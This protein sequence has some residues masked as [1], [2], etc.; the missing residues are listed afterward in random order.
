MQPWHACW[1]PAYTGQVGPYEGD[2]QGS[3]AGRGAMQGRQGYI[4]HLLCLQLR[5]LRMLRV[6]PL[7]RR[8]RLLHALHLLLVRLQRLAPRQPGLFQQLQVPLCGVGMGD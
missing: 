7:Q 5:P 4:T 3:K 1:T 8:V 6:L 2:K